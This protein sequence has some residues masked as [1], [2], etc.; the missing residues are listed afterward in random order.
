MKIYHAYIKTTV[1]GI[2]KVDV[3]IHNNNATATGPL[4]YRRVV[5]WDVPPTTFNELVT[6]VGSG[7]PR[8]RFVSDDGF[9]SSDPLTGPS[10]ID[11][12]GDFDNT[13]PDDHG[14]LIDVDVPAIAAGASRLITFYYGATSDKES[15]TKA[16]NDLGVRTYLLGQPGDNSAGTPNT[17]ILGY[18][19]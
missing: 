12:A 18:R 9:A 4:V 7:Q 16:M 13:G 17:F 1:P 15:A 2:Y 11:A 6:S 8:V 10:Q 3:E 19:S 5:D 14:S